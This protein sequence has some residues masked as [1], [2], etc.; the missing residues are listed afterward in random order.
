M[1]HVIEFPL[2]DGC[3]I[4][5]EVHDPPPKGMVRAG[6][7]GEMVG[8]AQKSFGEALEMLKPTAAALQKTFEALEYQEL[9]VDFGIKL[10]SKAGVVVSGG[11]EANFKVSMKWKREA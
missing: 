10:S 1:P 4:A 8:Q 9:T 2:E 7:A 6:R 11:A 5:V 3:A